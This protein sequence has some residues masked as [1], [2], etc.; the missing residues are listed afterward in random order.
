VSLYLC[1]EVCDAADPHWTIMRT[2]DVVTSWAC[3]EHLAVVCD[4]LQRDFEVTELTVR[5]SRKAREWVAI[6][7]ALDKIAGAA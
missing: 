3:D 6:G 5:N 2:G 4:R 7:R 1:C